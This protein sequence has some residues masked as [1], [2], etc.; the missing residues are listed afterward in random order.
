MHINNIR[1]SKLFVK[2][3]IS[4]TSYMLECT[5]NQAISHPHPKIF[6]RIQ[7][8]TLYT[9]MKLTF[10]IFTV[11][12]LI[13]AHC[14]FADNDSN[15]VAGTVGGIGGAAGLVVLGLGARHQWNKAKLKKDAELLKHLQNVGTHNTAWH[16]VDN[17]KLLND[18][19]QDVR[20]P[21]IESKQN[22]SPDHP[23]YQDLL[24]KF[25]EVMHELHTD[26]S[27]F[28]DKQKRQ[29]FVKELD[30]DIQR[31]R[32]IAQAGITFFNLQKE[33]AS[34]YTN[35]PALRENLQKLY[36]GANSDQLWRLYVDDV[37]MD[38]FDT[39][40]RNRFIAPSS[41]QASID[42]NVKE[43]RKLAAALGRK[44]VAIT[45][46]TESVRVGHQDFNIKVGN[47]HSATVT[48]EENKKAAHTSFI[49]RSNYHDSIK[50][51]SVEK[52]KPRTNLG[53]FN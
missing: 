31:S 21:W 30:R 10:S 45:T 42:D 20:Y 12:W 26:P 11:I 17:I 51:T 48:L 38:V 35:N 22:I 44:D 3:S 39:M 1:F 28:S 23:R 46:T 16:D 37:R 47:E 40:Y 14:C 29:D 43:H 33:V 9:N 15:V 53:R 13:M 8:I 5:T 32:M 49:R 52:V 50:R 6:T 34:S 36:P 18:F 19:Q 7:I 4:Y 25:N 24:K 27:T 41:F 2:N